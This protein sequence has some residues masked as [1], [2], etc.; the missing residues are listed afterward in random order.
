M[1]WWRADLVKLAATIRVFFRFAS[2]GSPLRSR[3]RPRH[4]F[5]ASDCCVAC[6]GPVH[7]TIFK[8]ITKI[9]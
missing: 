1:Y 6:F 3:P 8:S 7:S 4:H 9:E 2:R 5:L